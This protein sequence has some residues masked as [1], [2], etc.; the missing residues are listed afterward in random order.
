MTSDTD[1]DDVESADT[2]SDTNGDAPDADGDPTANDMETQA[3][4]NGTA[5]DLGDG[6]GDGDGAGD[7]DSFSVEDATRAEQSPDE[8]L[9]EDERAQTLETVI[10][11]R[12]DLAVRSRNLQEELDDFMD[13]LEAMEAAL[14]S[15]DPETMSEPI[16]EKHQETLQRV[17]QNKQTFGRFVNR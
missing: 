16:R 12:E 5:E 17:Q 4:A 15:A 6:G 13:A 11:I 1:T 9:F 8:A 7:V 10:N 14:E 2:T 3:A